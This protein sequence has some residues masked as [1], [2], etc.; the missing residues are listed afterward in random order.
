VTAI[1]FKLN[2]I[3]DQRQLGLKTVR[4]EQLPEIEKKNPENY[5]K[6]DQHP[7]HPSF[8]GH[9]RTLREA[10]A[11]GISRDI[12]HIGIGPGVNTISNYE[13]GIDV[14][15]LGVFTYSIQYVSVGAP[16]CGSN[17]M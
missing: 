11:I 16:P 12:S 8:A 15:P 1:E 14:N 2:S 10:S 7:N 5:R 13:N 3:C 4:S 17:A 9:K 6:P